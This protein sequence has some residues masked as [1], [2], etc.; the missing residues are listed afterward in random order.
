MVPIFIYFFLT[1]WSAERRLDKTKQRCANRWCPLMILINKKNTSLSSRHPRQPS[2]VCC[3]T[4]ASPRLLHLRVGSF[5]L[6]RFF[7][8][9]FVSSDIH[10]FCPLRFRLPFLFLGHLFQH[11]LSTFHTLN[12]HIYPRLTT[13]TRISIS[14]F[15][16][17]STTIFYALS[18]FC[19]MCVS[20]FP[21]ATSTTYTQHVGS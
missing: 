9:L 1:V 21:F 7:F 15:L 11:P 3:Q 17:P 5:A 20:R 14:V 13:I 2:T 16:S 8:S 18:V 12:V 10:F 4:K 6:A 19:L